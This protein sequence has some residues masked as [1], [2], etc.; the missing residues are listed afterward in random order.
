MSLNFLPHL[1]IQSLLFLPLG[2]LYGQPAFAPSNEIPVANFQNIL[3]FPWAGGLN[4]SQFNQIDL[5]MDNIPDVLIFDR[6]GNRLIPM[7]HEGT[8]NSIG[9]AYDP[10]IAS[11]LPEMHGWLLTA[12]Y[13]QDGLYDLFTSSQDGILVYTNTSSIASGLSFEAYSGPNPLRSIIPGQNQ[14]IL[15]VMEAD[16]PTIVDLDEDGDLDILAFNTLGTLI[17]YH[18][19]LSQE[20][21]GHADSLI[22]ILEE[23]CWGHVMEDDAAFTI[24][25][26]VF[27]KNGTASGGGGLHAGSTLLALDLDGDEDKE[28]ALGDIGSSNMLLLTNGG[29]KEH[30]DITSTTL[31]FPASNPVNLDIFPAAFHLDINFDGHRDLVISPNSVL[32][33]EDRFG[34]WYYPNIGTDSLPMFSF[35]RDNLFV[36]EMI[37][38]GS[39][40]LPI[41]VDYDSDGLIDMIVGN[42]G[43]YDAGDIVPQLDLYRNIG[44]NS[45]PSFELITENLADIGYQFLSPHLYPTLG[46]LDDDGDLDMLLGRA[47]GTL[48]FYRNFSQS[49]NNILPQF[50]FESNT[51]AMIDVGGNATPQLVDMDGDG[52]TDL[53][54]GERGGNVNYY[55]NTGTAAM[56]VFSL[57]SGTLGGIEMSVDGFQPGYS[58]PVALEIDGQL[59]LMVGSDIGVITYYE[60]IRSDLTAN[61]GTG[62]T[63]LSDWHIGSRVAPTAAD[64]NMDGYVDMIVGNSSG[65]LNLFM[66]KEP[67]MVSVDPRIPEEAQVFTI[68]PNPSRGMMTIE[69]NQ[70]Q[71]RSQATLYTIDGKLLQKIAIHTQRTDIDLSGLESG[72]YLIGLTLDSGKRVYQKIVLLP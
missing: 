72:L 69:L 63:L 25:T 8:A 10:M 31:S 68:F 34:A 33:T 32:D 41:L 37:D 14:Q 51:Y 18:K 21:H 57:E 44:T 23:A 11:A 66:G 61:F 62:D 9:Y 15:E 58:I 55:R 42:R 38:V 39:G 24:T 53:L 54:I 71:P 29:S 27:C 36:E 12:D 40:S 5:N 13:N 35:S 26:G 64:L 2:F 1:W 59:D 6:V 70:V 50:S 56:P 49:P 17:E 52:L 20:S 43:Y 28:L 60:D 22:F 48:D 7:I 46:D 16:I 30:A 19:N 67:M 3:D 47:D 45:M 4:A 65:G